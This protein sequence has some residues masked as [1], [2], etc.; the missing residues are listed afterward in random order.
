M[1]LSV[2]KLNNYCTVEENIVIDSK[3]MRSASLQ[4]F[5]S[6]KILLYCIKIYFKTIEL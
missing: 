4:D 6:K 5:Y 3:I 1:T 2:F